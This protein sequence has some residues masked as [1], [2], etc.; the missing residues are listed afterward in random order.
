MSDHYECVIIGGGNSAGYAARE[1]VARGGGAGH[2]AIITDEPYV[3]YER[4][5]LSKA[6]LAPESPARLPGFHACVGGGGDRQLPEWYAD[7]GIDYL[8]DTHIINADILCKRLS[9]SCGK[10]ITYDKLI[11]AT[12]ARPV[13]LSDFKT[14]GAELRGIHYL[15]NV[16]DADALIAAIAK[17]KESGGKAVC[18]G[19]G[20]AGL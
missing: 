17:T 19:G 13:N 3:S 20:E 4:P 9:S 2:L 10:H 7:H 16:K 8:T 12:G 11:I 18:I 14:P 5:A 6:Y 1:F 15:R